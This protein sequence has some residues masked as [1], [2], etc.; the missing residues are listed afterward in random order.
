METRKIMFID[1]DSEDRL[2]VEE[3]LQ[4]VNSEIG[5]RFSQSAADAL[6]ILDDSF[7]HEQLPCLIV[8]DVNMPKMSGPEL[9]SILK[10][11]SRFSGIPVI[12]YSTSVN[13]Y[14]KDKCVKLGAHS[15]ITKPVSY[16]ESLEIAKK[17]ID[18]CQV[19]TVI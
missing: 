7:K 14:E 16:T 18:A 12:I 6:Q 9:L 4:T 19:S 13:P 11:D 10:N 15:Y 17:F 3:A 5:I 1:D 2:I 8:L